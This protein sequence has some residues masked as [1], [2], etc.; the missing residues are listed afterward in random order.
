MKDIGWSFS[1]NDVL[2]IGGD[3]V[4]IEDSSIQNAALILL[5]RDTSIFSAE[6]GVGLDHVYPNSTEA[7]VG[8]VVT[9][10]EQQVLTDG[11]TACSIAIENKGNG[12]FN[13]NM[14][15]SYPD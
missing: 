10:A 4:V 12:K 13:V 3:F 9:A 7:E 8:A 11:A 14:T 2:V 15:A 6:F 1:A 5:K